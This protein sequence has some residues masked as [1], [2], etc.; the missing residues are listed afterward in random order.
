MTQSS[1]RPPAALITAGAKRIGRAMSARLARLGY[2]VAVHYH[3]SKEEAEDLRS[4]LENLGVSCKLFQ[5]DFNDTADTAA[6]VDQ[7]HQDLPNLQLLIN[8]ASV[9]H[10]VDFLKSDEND[11]NTNINVHLR[12]PYLLTREFAKT[13]KKG[14]IIN[15]VDASFVRNETVF[16]AYQLTKKALVELTLMSA[17]RLGP[18]I[19]VNAIAPGLVLPPDHKAGIEFEE[20]MKDNPLE[21]RGD[22]DDILGALDYL[23]VSEHV[24]G[25][26]LFVDGGEHVDF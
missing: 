2:D 4:Q 6:L 25:Q 1:A 19:R 18:D 20:R 10:A 17:R 15:L 8:S 9:F 14:Q 11:L 13:V 7:V 22:I 12:A 5:S 26:I 23:V 21:R 3:K 24:T 16:F